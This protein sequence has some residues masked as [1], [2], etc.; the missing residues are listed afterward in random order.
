MLSGIKPRPPK[1]IEVDSSGVF[2]RPEKVGWLRAFEHPACAKFHEG[3]IKD[4]AAE[5]RFTE[6]GKTGGWFAVCVR[7]KLEDGFRIG[8][9]GPLF[10]T[11]HIA[12]NF[13][14]GRA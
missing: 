3:I 13:P 2:H 4:L 6:N 14:G 5:D 7:S 10:V 12:D 8:H 11:G 9:N 1:P